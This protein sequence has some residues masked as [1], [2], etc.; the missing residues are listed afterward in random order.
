[1]QLIF[2]STI[3]SSSYIIQ[4]PAAAYLFANYHNLE[5][6]VHLA[7]LYGLRI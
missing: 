7:K 4:S 2:A 3:S 5:D 1:M 6:V